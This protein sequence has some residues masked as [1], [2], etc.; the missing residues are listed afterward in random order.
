MEVKEIIYLKGRCISFNA[1]I[2]RCCSNLQHLRYLNVPKH[3]NDSE[4]EQSFTEEE[5][6]YIFDCLAHNEEHFDEILT[7]LMSLSQ[8]NTVLSEHLQSRVK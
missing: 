2:D 6:Q 1:L 4:H 7:D 5:K 3:F 8:I